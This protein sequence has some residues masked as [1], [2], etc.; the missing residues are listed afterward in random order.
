MAATY[1]HVTFGILGIVLAVGM[2]IGP[3]VAAPIYEPAY[4]NEQTVIISVGDPQPG[5]PARAAQN[6]YYEVIYPIGW[7]LLVN[8]VPQ[9]NPCDHGGDGDDFFDYHDH[10]F[11]GAP[12]H[13]GHGAYGP[14]W[15][16]GFV[17]PSYN[18]NSTH[19]TA[20]S[21][22][23]AAH[24]PVTSAAEVQALLAATLPDGSAIAEFFDVDYVFRAAI[25]SPNAQH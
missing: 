22:A 12:G 25:V 8:H 10:V 14:L 17:V 5:H 24:L 2:T 7:Q 20:V 23:Y 11:A 9:C 1:G 3:A 6:V 15:R 19:D 18:G 16:L 13:S 21:A 4:A